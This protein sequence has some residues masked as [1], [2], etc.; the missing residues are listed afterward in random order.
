MKIS[1]CLIV[2]NEE[3]NLKRCLDSVVN[4]V[5]EIVITDT[6]STD[7]TIEIAKK[8]TSNIYHYKWDWNFSAARN[9]CQKYANWDY[10]LWLDAD[11]FFED[12]YI[13]LLIEKLKK[14]DS[15]I[16]LI[17]MF[18]VNYVWWIIYSKEEK[19]RVLKNNCWS[20][21]IWNTH[22]I[23]DYYNNDQSKTTTFNDIEFSHNFKPKWKKWYHIES[24]LA[25]FESDKNNSNLGLDLIKYYIQQ[26][27]FKNISYILKNI[28]YIHPL[29]IRKFTKLLKIF[30]NL[31]LV[32]EEQ[33]LSKLLKK[34]LIINTKIYKK[35]S[36]LI[37]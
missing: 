35:D 7:N 23:I 30:N 13:S 32:N 37:Y 26:E 5:D 15:N 10:I 27:K 1:V 3:K 2:K 29:F 34:S 17:H 25:L 18:I 14:I 11:E 8:Y 24:Y 4:Y 21:W 9:Y 16:M 28:W 22:E 33:L 19:L 31:K 20:K 6:W 12:I 36:R